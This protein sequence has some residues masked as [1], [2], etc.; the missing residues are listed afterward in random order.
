[1]AKKVSPLSN[2]NVP[3]IFCLIFSFLI[4]LSLALLSEESLGFQGS[5]RYN[6]GI[7]RP[8]FTVSRS[9]PSG[10]SS[11]LSAAQ[12]VR[13]ATF[14]CLLFRLVVRFFVYDLP[15]QVCN[16]LRPFLL[17]VQFCQVLSLKY[18]LTL[19]C[20]NSDPSMDGDLERM[21]CWIV[22]ILIKKDKK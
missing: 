19:V 7:C 10:A 22:T 8:P 2:P 20:N 3:D 18:N 11:S 21:D 12:Q 5:W 4:P 6:L 13:Q 16:L 1:M 14:A 15:Q 17:L 9:Y